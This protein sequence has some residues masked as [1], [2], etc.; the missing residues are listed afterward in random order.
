[1]LSD[2]QFM[3]ILGLAIFLRQFF[4]PEQ[5]YAYYQASPLELKIMVMF[6]R[7][8]SHKVSNLDVKRPIGRVVVFDLVRNIPNF[9]L[10]MLVV[11]GHLKWPQIWLCLFVTILSS[12][13]LHYT[14]VVW[15]RR[16]RHLIVWLQLEFRTFW[17]WCFILSM[18]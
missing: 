9:L 3:T 8:A 5:V 6:G 7:I 2:S 15:L 10:R 17:V 11:S 16:A 4:F 1:M 14:P 12:V 13:G 18:N